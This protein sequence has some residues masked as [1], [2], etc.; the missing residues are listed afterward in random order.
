MAAEKEQLRQIRAANNGDE[1]TDIG[2]LIGLLDR[3]FAEVKRLQGL[4]EVEGRD[5]KTG[6]EKD[7]AAEAAM[8]CADVQFQQFL[9]GHP[10]LGVAGAPNESATPAEAAAIRLR[11]LCSVKSRS[12]F[13]DD[14]AART[15]WLWLRND[16]HGWLKLGTYRGQAYSRAKGGE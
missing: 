6:V 3:S 10:D 5:P 2:F 12:A 8:K 9:I 13:N 11:A 16:F 14:A 1:A 4:L 15:R 7:Y